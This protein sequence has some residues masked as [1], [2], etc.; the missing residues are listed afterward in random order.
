MSCCNFEAH[1]LLLCIQEEHGIG[2]EACGQ[3]C[4]G[5]LSLTLWKLKPER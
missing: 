3:R 4:H 1:P 5:A 2:Q